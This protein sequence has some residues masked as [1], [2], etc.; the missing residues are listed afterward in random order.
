M[1][2]TGKEI[3]AV[4]VLAAGVGLGGQ[5]LFAQSDSSSGSTMPGAQERSGPSVTQPDTSPTIPGQRTP[6]MPQSDTGR[7]GSIPE[8]MG[9]PEAG[10][11]PMAVT[12]EDI[13]KAQDALQARGLNPGTDGRMD[14]KTQQALREFQ[15][16]NDLP[17]TG[18]LD[19][20]TAAKLG[21]H[22][23][24]EGKAPSGRSSG[25]SSESYPSAR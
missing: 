5:S 7:S 2:K 10:Q 23:G 21:V 3:L 6:G 13:K 16:A 25:S 19:E 24:S 18:V 14:A 4:G 15:Q 9:T 1:K 20:Q 8:H 22:I 17:V 11:K 12:S